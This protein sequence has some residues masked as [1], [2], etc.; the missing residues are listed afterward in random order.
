MDMD[1]QAAV[2]ALREEWS[3][4][5]LWNCVVAWLPILD[6]F[7][8]CFSVPAEKGE[9]WRLHPGAVHRPAGKQQEPGL[10][11]HPDGVPGGSGNRSGG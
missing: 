4:E 10:E 1:R 5:A 3:E 7:R 8:P 11:L 9:K 2:K 6:I